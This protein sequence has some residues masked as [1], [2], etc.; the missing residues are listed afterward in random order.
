MPGSCRTAR[1]EEGLPRS[2][3]DA[4]DP[5]SAAAPGAMSAHN[6]GTELGKGPA[7]HPIP[8]PRPPRVRPQPRAAFRSAVW[9]PPPPRSWCPSGARGPGS[10][11]APVPF[12][13][14]A[15][16]QPGD[17]TLGHV[18]PPY[19]PWHPSRLF[20]SRRTRKGFNLHPPIHSLPSSSP[21]AKNK[22][23]PP[24]PQTKPDKNPPCP[25]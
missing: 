7:D 16:A 15:K 14:R 21:V 24:K 20:V 10:G 17:G 23:E 4:K 2:E 19:W 5:A 6:R 25:L 1:K 12:A 8:S 9:P 3:P 18:D 11:V 13:P 22:N